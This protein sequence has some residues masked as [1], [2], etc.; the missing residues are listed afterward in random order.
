[1]LGIAKQK[2][3]LL[4]LLVVL[5]VIVFSRYFLNSSRVLNQT[6][7][8]GGDWSY[9]V[10]CPLGTYCKSLNQGPLAG[11]ICTPFGR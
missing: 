3:L 5:T 4:L 6:I 11:G 8:C 1:M 9:D 2:S 10:K 7:S